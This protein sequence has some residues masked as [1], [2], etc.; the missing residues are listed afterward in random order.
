MKKP[1]RNLNNLMREIISSCKRVSSTVWWLKRWCGTSSRR[2][3]HWKWVPQGVCI[4]SAIWLCGQSYHLGQGWPQLLY[5]NSLWVVL[6]EIWGDFR[7]RCGCHWMPFCCSHTMV[8]SPACHLTRST[9][10][11]GGAVFHKNINHKAPHIVFI[12]D[13]WYFCQA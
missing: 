6:K 7:N 2:Q 1:V 11:A 4:L 9:S 13:V 8:Q 3:Q 10:P 5:W 12:K